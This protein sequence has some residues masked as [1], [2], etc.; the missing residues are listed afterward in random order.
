[1]SRLGN[2]LTKMADWIKAPMV[3]S[4]HSVTASATASS[5]TGFSVPLSKSG[6]YPLAITGYQIAGGSSGYADVRQYRINNA[7]SGSGTAY[8]YI[9]NSH[10]AAQSWTVTAHILWMKEV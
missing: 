5:G 7:T 8:F 6:Y 9:H 2:I 3:V 4:T 10:S 1:M